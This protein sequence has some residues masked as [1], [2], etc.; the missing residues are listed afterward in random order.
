[1]SN[2]I[3]EMSSIEKYYGTNRVLK[4]VDFK[5]KE[6]E[7]HAL[8]GENGTGKTTLMNILGGVIDYDHG[9]IKLEN[10]TLTHQNQNQEYLRKKIGF[11]H[12]ELALFPDLNVAENLFFGQE[13]KN[14]VFLD[15]KKM[16]EEADTILKRLDVTIDPTTRVSD[17]DASYQQV[18][19]I[20]KGIMRESKV[21]IMDEP[22]SSLTDSE[23]DQMFKVLNN[24]KKNGIAII[25]ISHKLNE[26]LE[27]CDSYT[28]LRDGVVVGNGPVT[29]DLREQDLAKLMIGKDL[30]E[31]DV[32]R[33]R[34]VGETI[35]EINNLSHDRLY[36]N[37]NFDLKKGEIVG[38]TGLLGDGRSEL[39]E[40]VYGLH[41]KYTGDVLLNG[42]K[43]N[44]NS[45]EKS[46]KRGIAYV[47]RNRKSNGIIKDLSI[48]DNM[49]ISNYKE[50]LNNGILD[51]KKTR[52]NNEKYQ[53]MLNIRLTEFSN[54]I[55]SLSGG[56]QQKIVISRALNI[57]PHVVILDNPTQGVD[58]GSKFEIYHHIM[59]LA[60]MGI[61]FIVLSSEIPEIFSLCDRTYVMFHGEIRDE[62]D[63]S[64]FCEER[65]MTVATG[66]YNEK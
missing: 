53:K 26:V 12:Q 40:T 43:I 20:S 51:Q 6:G 56:N 22:T 58:V 27:I 28:V 37:V 44:C 23:I 45:T 18:V 42:K 50:V 60:D 35:L 34:E 59:N 10:Q 66:G 55:T 17:L 49:N 32:Y 9:E 8:L 4:N 41:P 21:L 46:I 30:D 39:F 19:E 57:D 3:V 15:N 29:K 64:E 52:A 24:L 2:Y 11:V 1:M 33:P 14:G 31:S 13:I 62:L 7:I 16:L 48:S 25:F 47:P 36:K 54:L 38:V 61:S 65:I 63:R 5:L